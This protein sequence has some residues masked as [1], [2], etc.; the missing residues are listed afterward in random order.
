MHWCTPKPE[1]DRQAVPT[2]DPSAF[3]MLGCPRHAV[4]EPSAQLQVKYAIY[5]YSFLVIGAEA[6]IRT[7]TGSPPTVFETAA[8]T[9]PP[10]RP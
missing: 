8:S 3:D 6:R 10:L 9:V 5:A 7:G 1:R 2:S 4:N